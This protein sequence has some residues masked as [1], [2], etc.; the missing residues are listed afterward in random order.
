MIAGRKKLRTAV[1]GGLVL[2][3]LVVAMAAGEEESTILAGER[4]PTRPGGICARIPVFPW[5]WNGRPGGLLKWK[6]NITSRLITSIFLGE[7]T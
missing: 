3:V 6:R 7:S 4:L 1:T 2:L 5:R